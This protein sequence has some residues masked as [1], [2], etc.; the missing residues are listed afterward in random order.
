MG[1]T[2]YALCQKPVIG[3]LMFVSSLCVFPPL[4]DHAPMSLA[5][6]QSSASAAFTVRVEKTY[7]IELSFAY[8][9]AAALRRD[10]IVGSRYDSHCGPDVNYDEIPLEQRAGLGRPIPVHVVVRRASNRAVVMDQKL[11]S[12]CRVSTQFEPPIASRLLGRVAL[13]QGDYVI[14]VT[15][16]QTQDGMEDIK[17]SFSVIT[18]YGK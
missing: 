11:T 9:D 5:S 13:G 12:L 4:V 15:N 17:T 6:A 8:P 3:L 2:A 14:E 1:P 16:L 10:E 7:T 18:G